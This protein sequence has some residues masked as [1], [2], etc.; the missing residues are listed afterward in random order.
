MGRTAMLLV[1]GLGVALGLIGF[2]INRSAAIATNTQYAYLKYM[3]ARNLARTAVH[4]MLRAY[5]RGD[6]SITQ[7]DFGGGTFRLVGL[8][9]HSGD[10]IRL[11][12]EGSYADSTYTMRVTL[13][14][15][16]AGFPTVKAAMAIRATPIDFT[17]KGPPVVDG[18]NYN[19]AGTGTVGF[20]DV[21]GV[22]TMTQ[23]DRDMIATEPTI[24]GSP[25]VVVDSS[26]I[27]PLK[28]IDV[29]KS[30]AD[31]RFDT[32][33]T[34]GVGVSNPPWGTTAQP[35]ITYCNAGDN[36]AFDIKF[37]GN[38][39]GCGILVVR[40]NVTFTG[41][42]NFKGLVIVEGFSST[43][44]FSANGTPEI[45][46]GVII[47]GT[48]AKIDLRGAGSNGKVLYSS[49]ALDKARNIGKLKYYTIL[50]WFE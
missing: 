5:D 43:V 36:P 24:Y 31:R 35:I 4:A 19:L 29:F 9:Q 25:P 6:S 28:Y 41:N 22:A 7:T 16:T 30:N 32:P 20:G 33:G 13:F 45:L 47:A 14:K 27:D 39:D 38:I 11:V 1:L 23:S 34:H 3:N 8:P 42:F 15:T 49:A 17:T 26:I 18:H 37:S 2:Q 40:G 50:D 21:P 44:S 10:T 12:T 48:N 46:G